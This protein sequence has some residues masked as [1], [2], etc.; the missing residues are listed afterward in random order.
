MRFP[1]KHKIIQIKKDIERIKKVGAD[2]LKIAGELIDFTVKTQLENL[3]I[4]H[5]EASKEE[6]LK[7]LRE[8]LTET[9][10]K[11]K[12]VLKDL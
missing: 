11:W 6:L 4:K 12:I 8:K 10:G 5:P 7:I 1:S 2:P 3:R 9:K